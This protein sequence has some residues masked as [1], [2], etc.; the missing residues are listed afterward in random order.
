MVKTH[1]LTN[2]EDRV[3]KTINNRGLYKIYKFWICKSEKTIKNGL[4][5]PPKMMQHMRVG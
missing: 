4:T 1:T 5:L 3:E 2:Y